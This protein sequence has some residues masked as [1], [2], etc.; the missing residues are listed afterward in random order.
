MI[1]PTVHRKIYITGLILIP[2]GIL[3][4][5]PVASMSMMLLGVNWL[6]EP[7][8]KERLKAFFRN[9]PAVLLCSVFFLHLLGLCW[10]S[11]FGYGMDDVRIKIPLFLIPFIISTTPP[12]SRNEFR[13]LLL[14][15]I[16]GIVVSTLI[17]MAAFW[18]WLPVPVHDIRDISLFISHIRLSLMICLSLFVLAYF[19]KQYASIRIRIAII[20]IAVW[21]IVFLGILESLTGLSIFV[22][23]TV[24]LGIAY[25]TQHRPKMALLAGL[26]TL[27]LLSLAAWQVYSVARGFLKT[28][29]VV[30]QELPKIS[31]RGNV[32]T[33]D[34]SFTIVENGTY[35]MLQVCWDEL[36]TAWEK[37]SRIPFDSSDSKG[38]AISITLIRYM[39]SKGLLQKDKVT[40]ATLSQDDI[41]AIENGITNYKYQSLGSLNSRI[42]ESIWEIDVYTK[43]SNPSGHSMTMRFEFWKTGWHIFKKHWLAGVGT[44]DVK[45][46]FKK[47]YAIDKSQ[48]EERWQLRAHNQYL[49]IAVAFGLPG[50]LLFLASLVYPLTHTKMYRNYFYVVFWMIVCI[51]MLT[52]DT[53][54]TQAGVTFYAFFNAIFLFGQPVEETRNKRQETR[55]KT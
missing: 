45:T 47:Q 24:I 7:H 18:H 36:R 31:P 35:V 29:P 37:K 27:L 44:G 33:N 4:S 48:L 52:E 26:L 23:V 2:L 54:E 46:M 13:L 15:F 9:K 20:V 39:A 3:F 6:S 1:S 5:G 16:A 19:F 34:S 32:Y 28:K 17:S 43:G 41:H 21:L 42:Y 10:T 22:V 38:N 25:F 8:Y 14:F 49:A 51:S 55:I 11:D 30:F 40:F 12:L 50:L 53:L